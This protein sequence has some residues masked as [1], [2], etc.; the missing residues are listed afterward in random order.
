MKP[1]TTET[2]HAIGRFK[3]VLV[4]RFNLRSAA[5]TR[6]WDYEWLR[7][8]LQIFN[9]V[10]LPS[11]KAQSNGAFEWILFFDASTPHAILN[12]VRQSLG[13][14][15]LRHALVLSSQTFSGEFI[16]EA[17][18]DVREEF[19]I[20]TRLDNDDAISPGFME[21]VAEASARA[22]ESGTRLP[23]V[24]N[25]PVG[26]QIRKGRCYLRFDPSSPFISL[27]EEAG[28]GNPVTV[29]ATD[30][31]V[32]ARRW[33]WVSLG[34]RVHWLQSLHETNISNKIG[35]IRVARGAVLRR[36]PHMHASG[37]TNEG[38]VTEFMRTAA[39]MAVR[40]LT[41]A[42]RV[43]WMKDL[44]RGMWRQP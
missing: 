23:I 35:G 14:T 17:I 19:V 28:G 30:H 2:P 40:S 34:G 22:V 6:A 32:A 1:A 4:T 33:S 3:H 42:H 24:I 41:R 27:L 9:E 29:H 8:R 44:V 13:S 26:Y 15:D 36:F 11:V 39:R 43:A 37:L 31:Q 25:P 12:D 7:Q 18:G 20:T 38:L 21:A 10:C 16:A 5:G